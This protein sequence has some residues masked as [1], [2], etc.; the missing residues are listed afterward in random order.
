MIGYFTAVSA[1]APSL[2]IVWYFHRRDAY[3]E[4]GRVLWAT[5]FLG[6]L[7]VAPV[8][9]VEL[10][11]GALIAGAPN[12]VCRG[13]LDAFFGA[14]A[15]EEAFKLLVLLGYSYRHREFN[16]PMDGIVYGVVASL[17]FAT[18]ENVL[19]V[20]QGGTGVA[21]MRA[22]TSVPSHAGEGAIMGYF[23][24][25]ARFAARGRGYLIFKGFAAAFIL[26]GVYDFPLLSMSA[27]ADVAKSGGGEP[28]AALFGLLPLTV[29]ALAAAIVWALRLTRKARREQ[30]ALCLGGEAYTGYDHTW[31]VRPRLGGH[32][33]QYRTRYA[34]PP[35]EPPPLVPPPLPV[36]PLVPPPL[37]PLPPETVRAETSGLAGKLPAPPAPA[38]GRSDRL[39]FP[40][41][42][43]CPPTQ[44]TGGRA[45]GI[46]A[47]IG[48]F[49]FAGGGGMM[50]LAIILSFLLGQVKP[51]ETSSVLLGTFIIGVL[52]LALGLILFARGVK[53]LNR[54]ATSFAG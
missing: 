31:T 36:P 19:Y 32:Q 34:A 7:T 14:S 54:A 29:L 16:E 8:V 40:P 52:P 30:L 50:T 42:A 44:P 13:A 21:V 53:R 18:L 33:E 12:V 10:G 9:A 15:P 38:P 2:L 49:V 5:F 27:A 4:P 1:I 39:P 43:S 22:L 47:V 23:V 35:P 11:I 25:V 51:E 28:S 37:L 6:V 3:P 24:G 17:G 41:P 48:G 45:L 26:H 46:V 20:F